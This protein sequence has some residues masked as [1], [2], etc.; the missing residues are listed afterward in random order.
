MMA[1]STAL[2][3]TSP[4]AM[5]EG[6][7]A[8]A[9]SDAPW[10]DRFSPMPSL[11]GLP[12]L[13]GEILRFWREVR[14]FEKTLERPG[15]PRFVF[16]EGPP[17][18]NGAP[19]VH[20]VLPRLDKDVVCRY[21]TMQGCLVERK[22]GWD[23]HGLPVEIE[24]E[25]QLGMSHKQDILGY[26]VAE[27]NEA[28]KGS[29]LTY[30]EVWR[31]FTERM[32]YWLDLDHP[33][34]TFTNDYIESVWYIL[35]RFWDAGLI[36]RGHKSLPYCPRCETPLSSHEVAQGYQ[37]VDDPS[38]TVRFRAAD[39]PGL[40]YLAWT[41]TPWTLPSNV[42]LALHPDVIYLEAERDGERVVLARERAESVLE[43]GWTVIGEHAAA[44]FVGREYQPLYDVERSEG[45]A[46]KLVLADFVSTDEGTGIV[47]MAPAFGHE[48]YEVGQREGLAFIQA[49]LKDGTFREDVPHWAGWYVKDAD[50]EIIADLE[51]RGL[52][53]H[54]E[55]YRHSYPFCWRCDTPLL[56][57]AHASWFIRT[58]E[59]ADR[60]MRVN[61]Q[62]QW[63][64]PEVG[65]GRF[66]NWLAANV[67]YALS[68]DR[69]WGTPLNLW[70][71]EACG[72]ERAIGSVAELRERAQGPLREPLDLHKPTVD[73]ILLRCEACG[74]SMRRTP[75]VID[76][77]FDSGSMPYAQF[78]Y[79]FENRE[80]FEA[81]FPADF[82]AEAVDQTRGWFYSLVLISTFLFDQPCFRNVL[83]NDF[84]LDRDGQKMSKSR[85]NIVEPMVLFDE[86]GADAVRWYLLTTS[87]P[88]VPTRFDPAGIAEVKRKFFGTL[89]HSY[90]FLATYAKIDAIDPTAAPQPEAERPVMDQW[91]LAV[92]DQTI[93]ETAAHLDAYDLT[94][95]VRTI[96]AF[97]INDLSNWYIRRSR[98]RFW[99][100]GDDADKRAAYAT[101]HEALLVT[102]ALMAPFAP[103]LSEGLFQR[104]RGPADPESVH[105]MSFPSARGRHERRRVL[106][107][108]MAPARRIVEMGRAARTRAKVKVRQPLRTLEIAG[109]SNDHMVY[110]TLKTTVVDELNVKELKPMT[111]DEHQSLSGSRVEE[112][113]DALRIRLDISLDPEL[114]AEGFAREFVHKV[115]MLRKKRDYELTDRINI[116]YRATLRLEEAL[117]SHGEF[118]MAE[119]LCQALDGGLSPT[120]AE[121]RWELNGEPV[122]VAIIRTQGTSGTGK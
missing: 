64:P 6:V 43:S 26:G 58:T 48:D 47:H 19:G 71:C 73:E 89:I 23:T 84:I 4:P 68:R 109:L 3:L 40:S 32:G 111:P 103:F 36:Y 56:Y 59:L 93:E 33:Y 98:R 86:H 17:T 61:E 72:A 91:L 16:Y 20:H 54:A 65:S 79:P 85:G 27:F 120:D 15:A 94:K 110:G 66:G 13:E 83:V 75:E 37:D 35:K 34:V 70:L 106:L 52:L 81:N 80:Q 96:E 2:R 50:P 107:D 105:L 11:A 82:I 121:V 31:E 14:V 29:V 113:D 42:A 12:H 46:Y 74:G 90:T 1:D 5:D 87:A 62:I 114:E 41:T 99:R 57:Y 76:C 30:V 7:A 92:M 77:W 24:V 88:W 63:Y 60:M 22:S 25:R 28:C 100:A 21:K 119:T 112:R 39:D 45:E 44:R 108:S 49:V 95:A 10:A 78:H 53:W 104:L 8:L 97:V 102:T 67:D 69:F 18:T 51:R 55:T 117:R 116:R 101:L 115:Q 38:I 9:E 122:S 118:I